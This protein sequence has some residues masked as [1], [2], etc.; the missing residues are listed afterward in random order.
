VRSS[1]EKG[2]KLLSRRGDGN[3]NNESTPVAPDS[4]NPEKKNDKE[5]FR[6]KSTKIIDS[7]NKEKTTSKSPE[8]KHR[9]IGKKEI[10]TAFL[11]K[12]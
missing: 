8:T 4:P 10:N 1:S 6:S 2:R 5:K 9:N 11:Q 7:I 12:K 3:N